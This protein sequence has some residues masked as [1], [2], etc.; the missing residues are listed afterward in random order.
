MVMASDFNA[1][2]PRLLEDDNADVR[3]M[4]AEAVGTSKLFSLTPALKK[5]CVDKEAKVVRAAMLAVSEWGEAGEALIDEVSAAL[6]HPSFLVLPVAIKAL[7]CMG[8]DKAV[9]HADSVVPLLCHEESMTRDA[10]VSFFE[11]CG[12]S[13]ASTADSIVKN[14]GH[15]DGRFAAASALALGHVRA[16]Q[17]ASEV[18]KLLE[19]DYVD[20]ISIAFYAAGVEPKLPVVFRRP[21]CA[22]AFALALMGE[23]GAAFGA[24][25]AKKIT[26]DLPAEARACLISVVG[27]MH[28][29]QSQARIF[30]FLEDSS[31]PVR[32]AAAEALGEYAS[33]GETAELAQA[34]A[35]KLKDHHPSVRQAAVAALGRMP[36]EG[37]QYTDAIMQL[38]K[39]R[40]QG[41]QVAAV[42]AMALMGERGQ[43]YAKQVAL[44]LK[45]EGL[46]IRIA[47]MEVL[48]SMG[49][50]GASFAEE[51]AE[52]LE[53]ESPDVRCAAVK[54]LG[55]M[56]AEGAE[57]RSQIMAV[58]ALDPEEEVREA[59]DAAVA[60][61]KA[62]QY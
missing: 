39:D 24:A 15:S 27:M 44:L 2:L 54:A 36:T 18:A 28:E 34:V 61:L 22:A 62:S 31:A 47:A 23:E 7:A 59:A 43:M 33:V 38:F 45:S 10:A 8:S 30:S 57:F 46:D 35:A 48:A 13:A 49:Q 25:V 16:K 58:A 4:A 21:A 55:A 5:C 26:D 6:Q 29:P 19:N 50:R 12:S 14:V 40:V 41:V 37:R 53:D 3:A 11:L 17:Y 9:A 32:A 42:Q 1:E 52:L 20:T 60:A 56:Q 51:V